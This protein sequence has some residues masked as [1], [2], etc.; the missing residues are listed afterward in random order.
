MY[1]NRGNPDVE[2]PEFSFAWLASERADFREAAYVS[3]IP[4]LPRGHIELQEHEQSAVKKPV[5]TKPESKPDRALFVSPIDMHQ[6]NGM[7][8]GQ[9]QLLQMLCG[10][11][12]QVD[13][14]SLGALPSA[15]RRWISLQGLRV[16]TLDGPF[17]W[18]SA[19]NSI[20]WY[21]GGSILCNKLR[22]IDRFH[23]PIRTP[24]PRAWI[25]RYDAIVCYYAWAHRLLRLERAGRKVIVD[26]GDVMADR[27]ERI[28]ARRWI[29]LRAND[30]RAVLESG[31]RCIAVSRDDA[32]EFK[33]LYGVQ[34]PVLQ[35]LPPS[36]PE[37]M[38]ISA[39]EK[40]RRVGFMG[41]PSYVN[42]EILRLLAQPEFLDRLSK[43]GIELV[44]AGG[45]CKTVNPAVLDALRQGGA[46]VL[47]R[48]PSTLLF[49]EQISAVLN[50]VGPSTGVKI[51]SVEALMAGR[52][53]V[54]TRWGADEN[55][56]MA[57]ANQIVSIVWPIDAG[58][59]AE[60]VVR[61]LSANASSS[62]NAAAKNYAESSAKILRSLLLP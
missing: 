57:F 33:R 8:E 18:I 1:W 12:E 30:E 41:A 27:H 2:L 5:V 7:S 3:V 61:I 48:V 46:R 56:R 24:L 17:A 10:I 39:R 16:R 45:I 23:F 9:V 36:Y 44:V 43:A 62:E 28:G 38:A 29:T 6:H 14:L 22:W 54:T 59:L 42:E 55:L 60:I 40:P 19:L 52:T 4:T 58:D 13:L 32:A 11:Y 31:S 15:A 47:G 26:T 51:K 35:F 25:N 34:V 21:G 50:P 37:L 49:Y 53:L 20:A